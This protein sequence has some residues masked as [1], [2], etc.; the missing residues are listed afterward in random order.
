MNLMRKMGDEE[1]K[2]K[3]VGERERANAYAYEKRWNK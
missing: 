1:M 3:E 2:I